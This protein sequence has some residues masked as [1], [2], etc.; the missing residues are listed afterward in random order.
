MIYTLTFTDIVTSVFSAMLLLAALYATGRLLHA[1]LKWRDTTADAAIVTGMAFNHLAFLLLSLCF[2]GE[3]TV[4]L[5]H[6]IH[7][8]A[9]ALA[10]LRHPGWFRRRRRF[11]YKPF[12][13][14][15]A[16]YLPYLFS[17]ISP[18]MNFDAVFA[19]VHN[20]EWVYHHGLAFNPSSSA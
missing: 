17:P 6:S 7:I 20:A 4:M 2:E 15:G 10:Y 5:M 11:H 16:L 9:I 13:I 14:L 18:P 1:R 3:T 8:L 12:V 19:Y